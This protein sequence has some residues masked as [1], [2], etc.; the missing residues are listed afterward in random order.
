M[1]LLKSKKFW[2]GIGGIA[3]VC[4][5]TYTKVDESTINQ[6]VALVVTMVLGQGLA[7]TGKD[8]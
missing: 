3:A 5:G 7:D 2:M 4:I 8:A 6:V 1:K